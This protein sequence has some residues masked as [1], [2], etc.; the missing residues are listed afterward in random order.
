MTPE[1]RLD[2]VKRSWSAFS[3]RD[4]D[5]LTPLFAPDCE[6]TMT[7]AVAAMLGERFIGHDGI[8]SLVQIFVDNASSLRGEIVEAKVAEDGTLLL[9]G[10]NVARS[11]V[12]GAETEF[13]L[14][15]VIEFQ[16]RFILRV[17][18][19][20]E[21]PPGWDTAKSLSRRAAR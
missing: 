2:L 5:A 12:V 11:A 8:R 1:D 9:E 21:P 17:T 3:N 19:L 20:E 14:W 16:D 6:W 13:R 18:D 10:R 4:A 15:Q 7:P